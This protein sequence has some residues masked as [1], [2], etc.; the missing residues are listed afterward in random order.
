[1]LPVRS[2]EPI[3]EDCGVKARIR[4]IGTRKVGNLPA[5]PDRLLTYRNA[6]PV[7]VRSVDSPP[8]R[9]G[10]ERGCFTGKSVVDLHPRETV[11]G[12]WQSLRLLFSK[13]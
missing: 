7:T 2:A 6:L 9:I 11:R 5:P 12:I 1:M 13:F 3:F 10:R 4:R 8:V